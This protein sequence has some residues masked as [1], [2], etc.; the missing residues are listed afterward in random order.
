M[1]PFSIYVIGWWSVYNCRQ[2]GIMTSFTRGKLWGNINVMMLIIVIGWWYHCNYTNLRNN[3]LVY[4]LTKFKK[5]KY[6]KNT[7]FTV[8]FLKSLKSLSLS[9]RIDWWLQKIVCSRHIIHIDTH[10][11]RK[12][13]NN[14]NTFSISVKSKI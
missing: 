6:V 11:F 5:K 1:T 4:V 8:G 9:H 3:V 7:R 10:G 12:E 14:R 13:R 2:T